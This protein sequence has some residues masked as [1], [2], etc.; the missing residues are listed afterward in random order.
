VVEARQDTTVVIHPLTD[1]A[2]SLPLDKKGETGARA[3]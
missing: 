1:T 2:A 3:P